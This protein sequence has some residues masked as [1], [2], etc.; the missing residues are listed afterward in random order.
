MLRKRL[1]EDVQAPPYLQ[2]DTLFK[3]AGDPVAGM[4]V[5]LQYGHDRPEVELIRE[6]SSA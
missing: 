6:D 3:E 5:L 4:R 2:D 1:R